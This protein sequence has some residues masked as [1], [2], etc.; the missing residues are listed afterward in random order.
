MVL[1][2]DSGKEEEEDDE[3]YGKVELP[4]VSF[5]TRRGLRTRRI[6]VE[7]LI[8]SSAMILSQEL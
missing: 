2:A 3:E 7:Q 6:N 4:V 5:E 1:V 8:A